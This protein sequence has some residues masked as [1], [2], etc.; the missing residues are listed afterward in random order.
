MAAAAPVIAKAIVG[1]AAAGAVANKLAPEIPQVP[2]APSGNNDAAKA[3]EAEA[4]KAENALAD[5][6]KKEARQLRNR[7]RSTILTSPSGDDSQLGVNRPTAGR[8]SSL[9]G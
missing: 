3:A 7:R 9:L 6:R 5:L 4:K 2:Q 1:T 8:G